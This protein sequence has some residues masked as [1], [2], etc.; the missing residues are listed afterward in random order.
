[1]MDPTSPRS[2]RRR[3]G[4]TI[5][6][7]SDDS[8]RAAAPRVHATPTLTQWPA[9]QLRSIIAPE[10]GVESCWM[11]SKSACRS[12]LDLMCDTNSDS[13]RFLSAEA[14]T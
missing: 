12:G 11:E 1:M 5:D 7:K 13:W 2:D 4:P 14:E 8:R 10:S 9:V 3:A 6:T